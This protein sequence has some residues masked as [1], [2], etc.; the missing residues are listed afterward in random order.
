MGKQSDVTVAKETLPGQCS[1]GY[2]H[3]NEDVNG[4]PNVA[5]ECADLTYAWSIEDVMAWAKSPLRKLRAK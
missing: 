3:T 4:L 2:E 5:G 1:E